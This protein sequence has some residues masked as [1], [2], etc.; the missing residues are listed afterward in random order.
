MTDM[1]NR[2]QFLLTTLTIAA[3]LTACRSASTKPSDTGTLK[4]PGANL[5]YAVQ[6]E[7]PPLL[8]IHGG[9]GDAG[10]FAAIAP[11]L[12]DRY[13]VITYDRRGNSRSKLAGA[14]QPLRVEQQSDD[15]AR[16]LDACSDQLPYVFGS[17]GGAIVALDLAARH[18]KKLRGV[19]AHEPPVSEVL[20]D[21]VRWRREYEEAYRIF[22]EQGVER[23]FARFERIDPGEPDPDA[24]LTAY[25]AD[26][27]IWERI[28]PNRAYL[29]EYEMLPFIRY[30]P[31]LDALRPMGDRLVV[32]VATYKAPMMT[33]VVDTL[34][35]RLGSKPE[36]FPGDHIGYA[37]RPKEFAA[38]LDEVLQR[39]T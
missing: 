6:G 21:A 28:E 27:E 29:L 33:R 34:T 15:A 38:K 18:G 13:Q 30:R 19:V 35:A 1:Q 12:A 14:P 4:V 17:S 9:V 8:M 5:Y 37:P 23:G 32:G 3:A 31:K 25:P 11:F 24:D 10:M 39:L 36:E 16:I 20:H 22:R 2:R 26:P 7:G